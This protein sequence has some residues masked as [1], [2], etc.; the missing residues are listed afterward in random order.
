MPTDASI[1]T[2]QTQTSATGTYLTRKDAG[3]LYQEDTL[4]RSNRT[5]ISGCSNGLTKYNFFLAGKMI[6]SRE[7]STRK[8]TDKR[9]GIDAHFISE[10]E[11]GLIACGIPANSFEDYS[12][13]FV[14]GRQLAVGEKAVF[15]GRG[16]TARLN[17]KFE[18]QVVDVDKP[19]VNTLWKVFVKH[20]K[21]L[22]IKGDNI[23]V[24]I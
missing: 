13:N 9:G 21:T 4:N 17:C 23:S 18:G 5:G 15:D 12:S 6:P 2:T 19:S 20:I 24:E 7:I 14:I 1:Y 22:I 16:K 10:L 11:K 3:A 8:T